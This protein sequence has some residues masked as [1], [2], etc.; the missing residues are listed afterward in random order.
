MMRSTSPSGSANPT[1]VAER[2]SV[3][4]LWRYPVKSLR[5]ERL[6]FAQIDSDGV[7]GDRKLRVEDERGL[8]TARTRPELLGIPTRIGPDGEPELDGVPWR[9]DLARD[10]VRR[11]AP[12]GR[13]V[14]TDGA[15]VGMRFD[16]APLLILTRSLVAELGVDHRRLRPNVLID[17]ADDREEAAWVGGTL[18]IG[19]ALVSVRSRCERCAITTV[20]P[21]TLERD[22]S[23]LSRINS[24]FDR[25]LGLNCEVLTPGVAAPGDDVVYEPKF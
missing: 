20:D 13:L 18:R 7:R 10:A 12:G 1:T 22:P 9:G 8:I 14:S 17:G 23:V 21:D 16:L 15:E 3:A 5:G 4:E 24:D 25:Q 19:S 2:L 11:A 6:E